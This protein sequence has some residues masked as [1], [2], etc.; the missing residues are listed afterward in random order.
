MP[1]SRFWRE[2]WCGVRAFAIFSEYTF[3]IDLTM[4]AAASA[5]K[6]A[7]ALI[8]LAVPTVLVQLGATIPPALTASYV[9]RHLGAAHFDGFALASVT[10]NLL[11]LSL[12]QGLYTACDTLM[13]QAFGV[14]NFRELGLIAIRG[15]A[16]SLMILIPVNSVLLLCM[17]DLLVALGQDPVPAAYAA[18]WY[19]IYVISLPMYALYNVIWKFLSAQ[20]IMIPLVFT[21]LLSTCVVLP[22]SLETLVP[23]IGFVGSAISIV[24]YQTSEI[25]MLACYL[26]W[27]RPH[28]EGTWPGLQAWPEALAP[29]PFRAYLRLAGGGILASSEWW[30]WELVTFLI[31]TLGVIP[32]S[33]HTVPTQ[34][35]MVSFM[36]P[37]GIGIALSIRLGLTLPHSITRAKRLVVGCFLVSTLIFAAFSILMFTYREAIFRVFVSDEDVLAGCDR[38]WWK[39]TVYF[40]SI[41]VF[42][43]NCG[44]ATGLGMQWTLGV[45][46]TFFLWVIGLPALSYFAI[47]RGGGV[48]T[49]WALIYPPYILINIVLMVAFYLADWRK[50]QT[51]IR[52]REGVGELME[53]VVGHHHLPYYG[54]VNERSRLLSITSADAATLEEMQRWDSMQWDV[55]RES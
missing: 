11:T 35:I 47:V 38:I 54:S 36:L 30:Y 10:G 40:F 14:G 12:L 6:E 48:D 23:S 43:I 3:M 28:H 32:L 13:P 1:P 5:W 55:S 20:G 34:V 8:D 29:K 39:V 41:G 51:D 22:L 31:G 27:K 52:K 45:V 9:G 33:V 24:L 25:A 49:A 16:G 21:A 46:N 4:T 19:R 2:T 26:A 53:A 37:I 50:I 17:E 7:K 42:G 15:F 18:Q 44:I